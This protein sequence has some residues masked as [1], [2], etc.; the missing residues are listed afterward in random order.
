MAQSVPMTERNLD[1]VDKFIVYGF[2]AKEEN[3]ATLFNRI[4]GNNTS[5]NALTIFTGDHT[6]NPVDSPFIYDPSLSIDAAFWRVKFWTNSTPDIN[7]Y[8]DTTMFIQELS[9]Y[10]AYD[11]G[12]AEMGYG[13]NTNGGK[14]A[15]R[16]DMV[17]GDSL[18]AVRMY[19]NPQANQP[20]LAQ[21]PT[22]SFLITVWKTLDPEVIQFQNYSFS[23]PTYRL[24]R[25]DHFVEFPLDSAIYVDGTFYIGWVQTIA[26]N[27]NLGFDRNR[28]NKN[29]IYTNT[30][31]SWSNT[32]FGGSLMMRPV[33]VAAVDP[34]AGMRERPSGDADGRMTV[35]PN[36]ASDAFTIRIDDAPDTGISLECIDATGRRVLQERYIPGRAIST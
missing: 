10:Y 26:V 3:D 24:D 30:T 17:G 32:A 33:F 7:R 19:F 13:L 31:G 14:L 16:F 11:D 6:V 20:P 18:R 9:N 8:N 5:G 21:P 15:Y 25:I 12:S 23:T 1:S 29:T 36:P 2:V 27:M 34:F 35:Y 28:N 22:G 4:S